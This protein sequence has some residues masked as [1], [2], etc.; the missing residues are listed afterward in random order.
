[1]KK[2]VAVSK[3]LDGYIKFILAATRDDI[4]FELDEDNLRIIFSAFEAYRTGIPEIRKLLKPRVRFLRV[5]W[6]SYQSGN[7]EGDLSTKQILKNIDTGYKSGHRIYGCYP[8]GDNSSGDFMITFTKDRVPMVTYKPLYTPRFHP[9]SVEVSEFLKNIPQNFL[10]HG[11][12]SYYK[13]NEA[14][15]IQ[16]ILKDLVK[17]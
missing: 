10:L 15:S 6:H 7:Y 13:G 5:F 3:N 1:M 16:N 12:R 9:V 14:R 2:I 17:C 11:M 4:N 8:N